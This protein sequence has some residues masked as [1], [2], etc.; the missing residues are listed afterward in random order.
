L[1]LHPEIQHRLRTEIVLLVNK[2]NRELTYY[3]IQEMTCLDM[4]V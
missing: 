4:V 3:G 1:A 2:H